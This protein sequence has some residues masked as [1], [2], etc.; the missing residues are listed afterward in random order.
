MS[1]NT[2]EYFRHNTTL[3][4]MCA[5]GDFRHMKTHPPIEELPVWTCIFL[6]SHFGRI[7]SFA[8]GGGLANAIGGDK[9]VF[10]RSKTWMKGRPIDRGIVSGLFEI[11]VAFFPSALLTAADN[12]YASFLIIGYQLLRSRENRPEGCLY[13]FRHW[14]GE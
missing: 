3:L 11:F 8:C 2:Y 12:H 14:L 6:P 7:D 5:N 1:T 4:C 9:C 10:F 13:L